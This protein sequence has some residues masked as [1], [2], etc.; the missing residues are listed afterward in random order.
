VVYITSDKR[1]NNQYFS[2]LKGEAMKKSP[3]FLTIIAFAL[4]SLLPP[5]DAS[6]AIV[7]TDEEIRQTI[8]T[9][10]NSDNRVHIRAVKIERSR[11]G[12][13]DLEITTNLGNCWG[14]REY[15]RE[16]SKEA[17]QALF[18]SN[19]PL[20]YVIVNVFE[21]DK[22]LMTVAL[23]KNQADQM[24]WD[25]AES[26]NGFYDQIKSRMTY[27]GNPTNYCWYIENNPSPGP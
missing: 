21:A 13:L 6:G 2:L 17:L 8:A 7:L 26:L 3:L 4:C 14:K 24:N 16:F 18:S 25:K 22:N 10:I 1:D 15:A 20:S 5:S 11:N 9:L 19:L 27:K 12:L 23:G